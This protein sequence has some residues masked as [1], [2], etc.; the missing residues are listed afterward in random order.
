M[1]Y[2]Q[3]QA[4]EMIRNGTYFEQAR[5]WYSALYIGPISERSFFLV[6]ALLA[7][8]I[9]IAGF[10]AFT[11]LMPITERPGMIVANDRLNDAIPSAVRLR[12]K[13]MS[14]NDAFRRYMVLQYVFSREGYLVSSFDRNRLFVTAHS[15]PEVTEQ[16]AA[17]VGESNPNN[18]VAMLGNIGLR[19]V[20]I[21]DVSINSDTQPQSATIK[22]STETG[23][24]GTW[25]KSQWTATMQF[26]Y[27]DVVV[28]ETTDP[29][30]GEKI[31]NL[32]EP[33]FQVVNYVVSQSY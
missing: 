30:S 33:I 15:S 29:K 12:P 4:D 31:A 13:E 19:Q 27:S 1:S 14:M 7:T 2:D 25:T 5:Q 9:G 11:G 21:L 22:F 28:T 10:I 3:H 6:I 26:N 17:E 18:P 16:Y 23:A 32:Q 24:S 8:L 20:D